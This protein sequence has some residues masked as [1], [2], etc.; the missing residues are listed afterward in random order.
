ML[1]KFLIVTVAF[2]FLA[3]P[4]HPAEYETFWGNDRNNFINTQK[5]EKY[6]IFKIK[7]KPDYKNRIVDFFESMNTNDKVNITIVRVNGKPEIDYCFFNEKLYSVSEDWG[8]I[9]IATADKLINTI[10]KKYSN[11]SV[12]NKNSKIIYSFNRDKTKILFMQ[13]ILNEKTVKVRIY[14][15]SAD[16]FGILFNE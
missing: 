3:N 13:S 5:S 8:E 10:K 15:Y 6:Y 7:E 11:Q 9:D 12:E 16:L 1:K 2:I 4:V 14:Y